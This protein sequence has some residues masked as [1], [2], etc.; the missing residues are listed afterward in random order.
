MKPNPTWLKVIDAY[1]A[2]VT[3]K[4]LTGKDK[5]VQETW[6][7]IKEDLYGGRPVEPWQWEIVGGYVAPKEEK[8]IPAKEL[9]V[10]WA[11]SRVK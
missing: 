8:R 7:L 11:F 4:V 9:V 6:E 2:P 3:G 10:E 1:I 5:V